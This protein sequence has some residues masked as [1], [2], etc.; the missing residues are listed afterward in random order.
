MSVMDR[1][2]HNNRQILVVMRSGTEDVL[3]FSKKDSHNFSVNTLNFD[4]E[5]KYC[6]GE[7]KVPLLLF[8]I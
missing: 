6:F 3:A 8:L 1:A 2:T 4:S 5:D 7:I